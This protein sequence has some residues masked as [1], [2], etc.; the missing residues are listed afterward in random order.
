VKTINLRL[1]SFNVLAIIL[2]VIA[3]YDCGTYFPDIV[4]E[5]HLYI[6]PKKEHDVSGM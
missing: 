3:S 6:L 1:L 2:E 4:C 5:L